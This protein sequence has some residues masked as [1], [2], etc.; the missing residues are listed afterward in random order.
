MLCVHRFWKIILLLGGREPRSLQVPNWTLDGESLISS[1][2]G[3][4]DRFDLSTRTPEPIDTDF[5]DANNNDPVPSFDGQRLS[6]PKPGR[7]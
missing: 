6:R 4:L 5:A 1:S 2:E 7:F 3:L